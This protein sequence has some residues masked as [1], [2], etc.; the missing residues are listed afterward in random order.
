MSNIKYSMK[1]IWAE[2]FEK[3]KLLNNE[4]EIELWYTSGIVRF[5]LE[6]RFDK[7]IATARVQ[8]TQWSLQT[9]NES[10]FDEACEWCDTQRLN[11]INDIANS[12]RGID[13]KNVVIYLF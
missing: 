4:E 11:I 9:F 1:E 3:I 5:R 8:S 10:S 12:D 7:I 6:I 13:D 2:E